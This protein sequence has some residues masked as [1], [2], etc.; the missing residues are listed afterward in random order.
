MLLV[1]IEYSEQKWVLCGDLEI[2]K[3]FT[4]TI[5]RLYKMF[6][7]LPMGWPCL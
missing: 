1:A 5:A 7:S 4:M 3:H 2:N 6:L